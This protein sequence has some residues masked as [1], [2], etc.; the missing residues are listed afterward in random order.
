MPSHLT[1]VVFRRIVANKPLLCH[2]CLSRP[3]IA[4]AL[5]GVRTVAPPQRRTFLA[6]FKPQRKI[7]PAEIPPGLEAL[8]DL[9]AA[10]RQAIR[11]PSPADI[12]AALGAFF[13]QK[14]A[15]FEDFHIQHALNAYR[16]L[17]EHPK[18]DGTPWFSQAQLN[19]M[20]Y[21]LA[22]TPRTDGMRHLELGRMLHAEA[23]RL[24]ELE[25]AAS[26]A[27]P[28][29]CLRKYQ[30]VKLWRFVQLLTA[31]GASLEA[32]DI[33][34]ATFMWPK[35]PPPD[36]EDRQGAILKC[37][38]LVLRGLAR[39]SNETEL[40]RTVQ[41]MQELSV[42]WIP[43]MQNTLVNYFVE[44]EDLSQAKHWFLQPTADIEVKELKRLEKNQRS[45]PRLLRACALSGD[46]AFGHQ[47]VASLLKEM[48]EKATWDAILIWSAAIGKG[49]DEIDRMIN[50]MIRRNNEER[51]K[52]PSVPPMQPDID[53]INQLVEVSMSKQD[54]YSAERYVALG[55][56]RGIFP[57][58]RTFTMQIQYRLSIGDIDGARTAYFGLQGDKS[59]DEQSLA[60]VNQLIQALCLSQHFNFDDLM[61]IVDDLHERKA[62][63]APETVA[64]LCLVHLRRGEL[65]DAVDL[66]Q[67][68]AH[69]F[70]PDQRVI[71]RKN[72]AS[73]ILD[74]QTSTADAWDAYQILRQAFPETP[75]GDRI[76]IM[77]G[78]FARKRSD[79][80]CH[81][82]FHMRN[83]THPE[84]TATK[85]VYVAAFTGF[86]RNLDAESL[87]LAHNQLKLDLNVDMDTQL[88]NSLMLA[89]A[90]TGNHKR[91][92]EIWAEIGAS[93]EG[94]TYN[95]IA[96]AFRS[97]EGMSFGDEHAKSIWRRLK[98]MDIEI[99]K[100]IY[101][102][103]LGAITRNHLHDEALALVESVEEEYGF[104]PDLYILGT[105]FNTT[106]NIER[107]K[108]VEEWIKGRYPE[109]WADFEALGHWVTMDGFGYRQYNL[110][111]D[112][113][114]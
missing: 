7:K 112:L 56:K 26:G 95:S 68:H 46:H 24:Y 43:V 63:L 31:F 72:L 38:N 41:L 102:A 93:K 45:L 83:E 48:P 82:F 108:Q 74:G 1:R 114:P 76:Q 92:L 65:H 64:A 23:K 36:W 77:N 59:G 2:G 66:L 35:T 98:E 6:M 79:M 99:D 60:A 62:R 57:N 89:H 29:T 21:R 78:F 9:G 61:A 51:Q 110:N 3:R 14:T 70:S 55:E 111:R 67:V 101:T 39:E 10:Q 34:A 30:T 5:N 103:Y 80:A 28:D 37:W 17:V 100:N 4:L 40:L 81:V 73:F 25:C 96:I 75:R 22:R 33:A 71:I 8:A 97:C 104:K 84:L 86:A 53:T 69:H 13:A 88:R 47:I 85:D 19:V 54:S 106:V 42:P 91:A 18:E 15:P 20:V 16:F 32:R 105:W 109:V 113:D 90:A 94:P 50:V 58:E 27:K 11:L 12:A 49:P 44:K 107:Q 87:E 52:N